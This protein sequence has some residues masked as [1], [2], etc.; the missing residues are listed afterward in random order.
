[1]RL[2][3]LFCEVIL[4]LLKVFV[5]MN[6]TEPKKG[7]IFFR[8]M[9]YASS[10][11]LAI[12]FF[13][14]AYHQF[15]PDSLAFL[16]CVSIPSFVIYLLV[17]KKKGFRFYVTFCMVETVAFIFAFY[18]RIPAMLGN[19]TAGM[20]L[21]VCIVLLAFA[22]Y[23]FGDKYFVAYREL[24]NTVK[25]GWGYTTI[26]STL[27]YALLIFSALYPKP[28]SK[29]PEYIATY[30]FMTF[31]MLSFYVVFVMH[32]V[33]KKQLL[34]LNE[35][36]LTE[37]QWHNIAYIDSLTGM[38]NRM[39]FV[40][41]I[42]EE[43]RNFVDGR[44]VFAVMIDIDGFKAVNDTLGHHVGDVL[45]KNAAEIIDG[46]FSDHEYIS[47]RIGGDEF[48]IIATNVDESVLKIKIDALSSVSLCDE[49]PCGFSAGYSLVKI[50]EN[51]AIESAFVRADREM[52]ECKNQK[53]TRHQ[54][55][56]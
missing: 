16:V 45:L 30:C 42:N 40:E 26:C 20:I 13:V 41:R 43:E 48:A 21:S 34:E 35:Q 53:K 8:I 19:N 39:A 12:A 9:M 23:I 36:L 46:I 18:S 28:I 50:E 51:N 15:I 10:V 56:K 27:I 7:N 47:F 33:R 5:F 3:T 24:M 44:R 29:R 25:G 32:L 31:V 54:N 17:A 55:K 6:M 14:C 22:I 49:Q 37:K 2:F 38:N 1:M 52:Y 4:L 11:P